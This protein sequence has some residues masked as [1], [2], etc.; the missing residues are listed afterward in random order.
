MVHWNL[1]ANPVDLEQREG[2][3]HR[4]KNHAVR[5]N[6]ASQYSQVFRASGQLG[7]PWQWMFDRAKTDRDSSANDLVPYWVFP[8]EASIDR[9]VPTL[10]LSKERQRLAQLQR[11]LAMYRIVFGQSRQDDLIAFLEQHCPE[12]QREAMIRE[13]HIDLRPPESK[14]HQEADVEMRK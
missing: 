10:P 13:L 4:Y 2:R 8:G 5:K 11:S 1:P 7:D 14:L 6:V 9:H 3:V 12:E